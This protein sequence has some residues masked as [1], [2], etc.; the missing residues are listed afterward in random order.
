MIKPI[1]DKLLTERPNK[2][3]YHYT[4]IGSLMKII[5]S[6]CF[7]ATEIHYFNDSSEL[8]YLGDELTYVMNAKTDLDSHD[9]EVVRQ[10]KI[11]LRDRLESGNLIFVAC[12]TTNGNLL[13][14][15]RGY[16][17]TGKGCSVGFNPNEITLWAQKQDFRIGK[18]V[19]NKDEQSKITNEIV[20]LILSASKSFVAPSNR[21]RHPSQSYHGLFELIENDLTSVAALFK[22]TSFHEE[23]EWRIISQ[24]VNNY[25]NNP[26]EYKEGASTLIPYMK[27]N[28]PSSSTRTISIEHVFLGPTPNQNLSMQSLSMY[29]AK[30]YCSP[31]QGI[32][33]CCIP[34]RTW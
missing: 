8:K 20:N 1:L 4:S 2:T 16:T 26:I 7:H 33:Y 12:F 15:W 30:Q 29:L 21:Q 23:E 22:N 13:S 19:Y 28:L 9:T 10:F 31:S 34:Y 11:W 25:V 3:L 24:P 32:R 27:Y 14:Q 5:E 17:P 18:C 6:Q